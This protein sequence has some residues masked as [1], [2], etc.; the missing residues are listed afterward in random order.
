MSRV[1]TYTCLQN[2]QKDNNIMRPCWLKKYHIG[3]P[4]PII[5]GRPLDFW[6]GGGGGGGWF[7]KKYPASAYA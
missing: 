1:F 5:R 4:N 3:I 6:G 2:R 7:W